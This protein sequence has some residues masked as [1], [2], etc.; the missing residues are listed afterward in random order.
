VAILKYKKLPIELFVKEYIFL[1][2]LH[3][4]VEILPK[5]FNSSFEHPYNTF[6]IRSLASK[7]GNVANKASKALRSGVIVLL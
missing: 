3:F 4:L 2:L 7:N 6:F 5:F 1:L